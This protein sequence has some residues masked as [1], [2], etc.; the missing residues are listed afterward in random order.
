MDNFDIG[1]VRRT[2]GSL[3]WC[4]RIFTHHVPRTTI[5][6]LMSLLLMGCAIQSVTEPHTFDPDLEPT[7][8]PT[9]V[10][11]SKPT[12]TVERGT[13]IRD[14]SLS[15][16]VVPASETEVSFIVSGLLTDIYVDKGDFVQTGDLI[17]ELD[18]SAFLGERKLAIN[19]LEV[20][21]ARLAAV[22]AQLAN[23]QRR[24]EIALEQ[25]QIQLNFAIDEAGDEPTA[26]QTMA[27]QLLELDVELAQITLDELTAGADPELLAEVEQ[28]QLR[29]DELDVQIANTKLYAPIDGTV[30]RQVVR[31]DETIGVGQTAV[32]LADL[33]NLEVEALV[34]EVNLQEM[35]EGMPAQVEFATQP[36]ETF[37][38]IAERLSLPYGTDETLP[39]T[40][41]RFVFDDAATMANF[42]NGDRL[43]ITLILV[44]QVDTLW[45]PPAAVRDFQGRQFVVI[46]D[47]ETQR[48]VDVQLGVESDGRLEILEG[49]E[50]GDVIVGP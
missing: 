24:A 49:V 18:A 28:A 23:E 5:L 14:L 11:I 45:L 19:S 3:A 17:A 34:R 33:S 26:S 47:E 50:E 15:G 43:V 8:V 20:A 35:F 1:V 32:V 9:A 41:A 6:L 30:V 42:T 25:I 10:A 46:Q 39:E 48:R 21:E 37:D 22:E 2:A 36:G 38:V 29:L 40:T 27:I 44:E 7:A 31:K 12:Y 13:V 16:Q 4:V